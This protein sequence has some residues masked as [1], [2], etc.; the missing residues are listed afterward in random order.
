KKFGATASELVRE[1][2]AMVVAG[3]MSSSELDEFC[4][5]NGYN[6]GSLADIMISGLFVALGEGWEW[7]H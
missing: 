1:R 6:P 5:D 3:K 7:E 2:A 4:L